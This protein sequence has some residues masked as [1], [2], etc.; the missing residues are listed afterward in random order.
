[1]YWISEQCDLFLGHV[2]FDEEFKQ[3]H[4]GS[5]PTYTC[6]RSWNAAGIRDKFSKAYNL[7]WCGPNSPIIRKTWSN[8]M[9]L[10]YRSLSIPWPLLFSFWSYDTMCFR[11]AFHG[12]RNPLQRLS[13]FSGRLRVAP[14]FLPNYRSSLLWTKYNLTILSWEFSFFPEIHVNLKPHYHLV[15]WSF[16]LEEVNL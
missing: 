11:R 5:A 8:S 15:T 2:S 7:L 9:M 13:W 1:M 3:I 10:L 6:N 4:F 16:V 12:M 14:I